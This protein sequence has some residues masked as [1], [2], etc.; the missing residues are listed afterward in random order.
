MVVVCIAV[1]DALSQAVP[2]WFDPFAIQR[3]KI[4][5]KHTPLRIGDLLQMLA[6]PGCARRIPFQLALRRGMREIAER[7][8]HLAQKSSQVGQQSRRVRIC[9]RKS[10]SRNKVQ[11][12]NQTCCTGGVRAPCHEGA[13]SISLYPRGAGRTGG[14]WW[15]WV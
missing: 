8:V 15:V 7:G 9:V 13:T 1:N 11:H 14:G 4:F 5:H 2:R 6:N 3:Q 12:P 10:L